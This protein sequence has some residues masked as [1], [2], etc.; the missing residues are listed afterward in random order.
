[1]INA[2]AQAADGAPEP[3]FSR[4]IRVSLPTLSP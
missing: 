2:A 3:E 4:R 1:L